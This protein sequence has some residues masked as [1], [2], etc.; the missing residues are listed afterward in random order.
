MNTEQY[1]H[2]AE[3][4]RDEFD[5]LAEAYGWNLLDEQSLDEL[6]RSWLDG[7]LWL[8]WLDAPVGTEPL[9]HID[10]LGGGV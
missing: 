8:M 1:A 7:Q 2:I 5:I 6:W 10:L 4:Y 9:T 3:V